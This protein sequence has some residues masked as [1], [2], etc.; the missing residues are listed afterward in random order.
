MS[1]QLSKRSNLFRGANKTSYIDNF[2]DRNV[3]AYHFVEKLRFALLE[4][5]NS[6]FLN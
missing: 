4:G 1:M 5:T 6:W 3:N 2:L